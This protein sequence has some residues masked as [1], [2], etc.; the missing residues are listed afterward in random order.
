LLGAIPI[1][2]AGFTDVERSPAHEDQMPQRARGIQ[3]NRPSLAD[4]EAFPKGCGGAKSFE[5]VAK[6]FQF[7]ER[8]TPSS[9]QIRGSGAEARPTIDPFRGLWQSSE[10]HAWFGLR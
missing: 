3:Q 7:G 2:P 6:S 4:S 8:E 5:A 9:K 1:V 10:P